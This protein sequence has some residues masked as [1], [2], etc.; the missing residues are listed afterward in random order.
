M[1]VHRKEAKFKEVVGLGCLYSFLTTE[2]VLG[3]RG[4]IIHCGEVPRTHMRRLME[5]KG[6]SSEVCLCKFISVLTLRL[7]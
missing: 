1:G 6:G 4:K 5:D 7:Q 3:L 2:R